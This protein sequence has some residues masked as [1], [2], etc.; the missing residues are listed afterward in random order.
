M[1]IINTICCVLFVAFI[2]PVKADLT[3]EQAEDVAF[4]AENFILEGN[5]RISSDGFPIFAYMQGQAR[6]DGY[7]EKL[8]HV[9]YDY[10]RKNY[11]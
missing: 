8:Y 11:I 10:K 3:Q 9:T 2:L 7:Q 5:K 4:F 1:K 6:I